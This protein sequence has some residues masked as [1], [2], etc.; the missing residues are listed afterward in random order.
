[1]R[2]RRREV[3]GRNQQLRRPEYVTAKRAGWTSCRHW[4]ETN[5]RDSCINH[6]FVIR[7]FFTRRLF[8]N[9]DVTR[10]FCLIANSTQRNITRSNSAVGESGKKFG[11]KK[12][13][14]LSTTAIV[15]LSSREIITNDSDPSVCWSNL[16]FIAEGRNKSDIQM[17]RVD[18]HKI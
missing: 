9:A 6:T 17:A 7:I 16:Q 4:F 15:F 10:F 11:K 3:R 14:L 5:R 13:K 1:M 2:R 18:K 12:I 8:R